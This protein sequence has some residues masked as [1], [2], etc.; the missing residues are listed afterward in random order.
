MVVSVS[1]MCRLCEENNNFVGKGVRDF[2]IQRVMTLSAIRLGII[3]KSL[4]DVEKGM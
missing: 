1:S 4:K 2:S 3:L